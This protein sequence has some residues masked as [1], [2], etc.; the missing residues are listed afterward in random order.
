MVKKKTPESELWQKRCVIPA[1]NL[2]KQASKNNDT[3]NYVVY[4]LTEDYC[5]KQREKSK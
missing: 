5:A 3:S 1:R 2:K 4:A